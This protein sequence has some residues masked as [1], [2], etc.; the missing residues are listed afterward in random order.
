LEGKN[1]SKT[2]ERKVYN[3]GGRRGTGERGCLQKSEELCSERGKIDSEAREN[4]NSEQVVAKQWTPLKNNPPPL[5][6]KQAG[7]KM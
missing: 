1:E 3:R 5:N 7:D 4:L 6:K 2:T